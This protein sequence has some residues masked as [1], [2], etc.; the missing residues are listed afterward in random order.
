MKGI[1]FDRAN[2]IRMAQ[3]N[4]MWKWGRRVP[5]N[6]LDQLPFT[7]EGGVQFT[8]T[9]FTDSMLWRFPMTREGTKLRW[10]IAGEVYSTYTTSR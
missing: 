6:P 4:S 9:E 10:R 7:S 5:S 3:S 8:G 1:P 2:P